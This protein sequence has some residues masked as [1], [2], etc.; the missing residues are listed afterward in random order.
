MHF[1]QP[2]AH[3]KACFTRVLQGHIALDSCVPPP[4]HSALLFHFFSVITSATRIPALSLQLGGL[5][6]VPGPAGGTL[7]PDSP[8]YRLI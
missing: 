3:Q 2:T 6:W 5:L 7:S 4:P 8:A 1:G